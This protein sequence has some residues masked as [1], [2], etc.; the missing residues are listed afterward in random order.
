MRT[1][2]T[3]NTGI[4]EVWEGGNLLEAFR[5]KS[6]PELSFNDWQKER[7]Q[8]IHKLYRVEPHELAETLRQHRLAVI[9]E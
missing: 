2:K 4:I 7:D 1:I 9:T 5:V 8:L 3:Y 6:L